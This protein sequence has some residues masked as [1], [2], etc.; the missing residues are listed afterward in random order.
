M[1]CASAAALD[2]RGWA[3][4]SKPALNALRKR[5]SNAFAPGITVAQQ[6]TQIERREARLALETSPERRAYKAA[7]AREY[8]ARKKT[9]R[10]SGRAAKGAGDPACDG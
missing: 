2:R 7:K 5:A 3:L 9:E 10:Q 1:T 8:R 6:K 4:I